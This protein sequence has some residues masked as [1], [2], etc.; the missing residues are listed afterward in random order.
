MNIQNWFTGVVEDVNDPLQQGRVRVRC[1][2]YHSQSQ[3]DIPTTDLPWATCIMPVTSPSTSGIGQSPTGL[4]PG[5]WV[6]GFFRDGLELQDP[7]ILG[8][9]PSSST[10]AVGDRNNGFSDPHGVFPSISGPDIPAGATTY[11]YGQSSAFADSNALTQ[12][13]TDATVGSGF[14]A[15]SLHGPLVPVQVNSAGLAKLIAAAK[16]EIGVVETSEN[17][18]PGIAKYWTATEYKN[19]FSDRAKWCAAFACWCIQQSG[20]FSEADRPKNAD[21]FGFETWARSKGPKVQLKMRPN[22]IKAGDIVMFAISHVGIA[23]S[24]SDING[25]F[26]TID[27]N[28]S[29]GVRE[30]NRTLSGIRSAAT[31][32]A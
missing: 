10:Q 32:V 27:G 18:G 21:A 19:G 11:G 17:Q 30:R 14:T 2:T 23:I 20:L 6:F 16:G 26:R 13:L 29:D 15:T 28:S 5:S 25:A 24:D 8:T 3:F 22:T 7:A 31:I 1:F 4:V 9:I 12:S